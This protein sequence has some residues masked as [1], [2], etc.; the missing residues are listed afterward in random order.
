MITT[1]DPVKDGPS[2]MDGPLS[3]DGIGG[4]KEQMDTYLLGKA[5]IAVLKHQLV[6]GAASDRRLKDV[7]D[8]AYQ[9]AAQMARCGQPELEPPSDRVHTYVVGKAY[10]AV[11]KHQLAKGATSSRPLKDVF[12]EAYR[13][14]LAL[15]RCN[16]PE[17]EGATLSKAT[18]TDAG[19]P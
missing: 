14:A 11:L 4:L 12:D 10:I 16:P 3:Q 19:K 6:Q 13:E 15:V 17:S 1:D 8:D 5:Y 2:T 18:V 7:F 9:E